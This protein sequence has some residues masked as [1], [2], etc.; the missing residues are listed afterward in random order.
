MSGGLRRGVRDHAVT[1]WPAA[2]GQQGSIFEEV[3]R[4]AS[5]AASILRLSFQSAQPHGCSAGTVRPAH[6]KRGP[7]ADLHRVAH[8]HR[9]RRLVSRLRPDSGSGRNFY[10]TTDVGGASNRGTVF[11]LSPAG[12]GWVL[13]TLYSFQCQDD[14]GF[15]FGG[16]IFGPDGAL[17][18]TTY[19]CGKD[20]HGV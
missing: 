20:D 8:L 11:R 15:V 9:R 17:Y 12:S 1:Q 6:Y 2:S 3:S 4:E 10:G 18:G 16:V 13:T 19:E 7:R 14:G 5:Q